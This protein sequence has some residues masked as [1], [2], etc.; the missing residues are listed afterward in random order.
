MCLLAVYLSCDNM[1]G[2]KG[3]MLSEISHLEKEKIP[4]DFTYMWNLKNKT[5]EQMKNTLKYGEKTG[6]SK[7][8]G[9]WRMGEIKD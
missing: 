9:G 1:G 2:L 7:R 5:N 6:G 3:I 4:Y 8:G